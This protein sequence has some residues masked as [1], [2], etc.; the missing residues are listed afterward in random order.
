MSLLEIYLPI[1][2][3]S[4]HWLL[5]RLIEQ[6]F[7]DSSPMLFWGLFSTLS[8]PG[9]QFCFICVCPFVLLYRNTWGWVIYKEKRFIWFTVLQAVQEARCQHLLLVKASGSFHPWRKV[10]GSRSGEI[11]GV[12]GNKSVVG[13]WPGS[14]ATSSLGTNRGELYNSFITTSMAASISWGIWTL[15]PNTSH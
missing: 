4:L 7:W 1:L 8:F 3:S 5:F 15:N 10:K 6:L 12:R 9:F 11:H 13:E 2:C 14:L